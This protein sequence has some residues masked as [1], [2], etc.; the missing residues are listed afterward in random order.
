[1]ALLNTIKFIDRKIIED[2]R[3]WFY[4]VIDGK[5]ENLPSFTGEI[6]LTMGKP[7]ESK[8]GHYHNIAN[9]WFT[10]IQGKCL[11]ELCDV[12]TNEK[13]EFLLGFQDAKTLYVPKGIAHNF[14]NVSLDN[15][16]LLAY[17]DVLFEPGDTIKWNF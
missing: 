12:E 11:V 3:G 4:K 2:S 13:K 1:M 10:I 5:E 6:Y 15:F 14:K 9:E 8:G 7:G 17:T 16:I